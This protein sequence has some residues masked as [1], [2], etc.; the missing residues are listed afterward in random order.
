MPEIEQ[1]V[2]LNVNVWDC[3]QVFFILVVKVYLVFRFNKLVHAASD[4]FS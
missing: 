2:Q 4:F 3:V 1:S